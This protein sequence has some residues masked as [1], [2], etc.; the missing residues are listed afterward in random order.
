MSSMKIENLELLKQI[1]GLKHR[2]HSYRDISSELGIP[3]STIQYHMA[4]LNEAGGLNP[5]AH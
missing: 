3:K 4:K 5:T 2:G 1:K